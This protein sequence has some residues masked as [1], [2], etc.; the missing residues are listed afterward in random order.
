MF[1]IRSAVSILLLI[2]FSIISIPFLLPHPRTTP[3]FPTQRSDFLLWSGLITQK[4]PAQVSCNFPL[5]FY[6]MCCIPGLL[7]PSN[8][9]SWFN[10]S[11]HSKIFPS[12]F[13]IKE[14]W[15]VVNSL[16]HRISEKLSVLLSHLIVSLVWYG[17]LHTCIPFPM[18]FSHFLILSV[19]PECYFYSFREN[20]Q[21]CAS[22]CWVVNRYI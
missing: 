22:V 7:N 9:I 8:S 15:R 3:L 12:W 21:Q 6:R 1:A 16:S 10:N 19:S 2:F 14:A 13:L 4:F 17:F 18:F 20:W 11:I 5:P